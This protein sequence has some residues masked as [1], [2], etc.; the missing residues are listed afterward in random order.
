M[1]LL[2]GLGDANAL[3]MAVNFFYNSGIQDMSNKIV[4]CKQVMQ[5]NVRNIYLSK[6]GRE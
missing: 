1:A 2:L 3:S 4:Q 5:I 6:E